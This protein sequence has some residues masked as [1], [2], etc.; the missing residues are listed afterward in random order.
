MACLLIEQM[1]PAISHSPRLAAFSPAELPTVSNLD[2]TLREAQLSQQK[3]NPTQW[4]P[5]TIKSA[6]SRSRPIEMD[7]DGFSGLEISV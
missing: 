3:S 2:V 1:M 4:L 6:N 7:G 5:M